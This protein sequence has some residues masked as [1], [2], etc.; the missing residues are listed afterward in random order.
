MVIKTSF[1]LS[2]NLHTSQISLRVSI[3]FI[4]VFSILKYFFTPGYLTGNCPASW[5]LS[6]SQAPAQL[7]A[8]ME[9]MLA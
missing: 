5:L 8:A 3:R 7:A 6:S 1:Q 2:D 9:D 4:E